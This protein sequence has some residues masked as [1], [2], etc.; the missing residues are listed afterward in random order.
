MLS[1]VVLVDVPA[2]KS[3]RRSARKSAR[4]SARKSARKSARR[5][6]RKSDSGC[7]QHFTKRYT[8][9]PSPPYPAQNCKGMRKLG[10]D[11]HPWNSERSR[12]GTYRWV[13]GNSLD[14][15]KM[16]DDWTDADWNFG[17]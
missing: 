7:E 12:N 10:N 11:N 8:S 17:N 16:D 9:R 15:L 6:A 2:R 5:S 4:R 3:A 1:A 13:R 14:M